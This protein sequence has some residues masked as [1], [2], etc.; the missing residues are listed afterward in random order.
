MKGTSQAVS[1]AAL[2]C[3]SAVLVSSLDLFSTVSR[4][5]FGLSL[6]V[7][8]NLLIRHSKSAVGQGV[9]KSIGQ[10]LIKIPLCVHVAAQKMDGVSCSGMTW[11][12]MFYS[13]NIPEAA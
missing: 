13:Q 6:S 5:C 10:E 4:R 1:S 9:I 8:Q 12:E 11:G 2:G 7:K 3:S